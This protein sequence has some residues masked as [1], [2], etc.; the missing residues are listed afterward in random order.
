MILRS[1]GRYVS[2]RS[3]PRHSTARSPYGLVLNLR[4]IHSATFRRIPKQ[5]SFIQAQACF[6]HQVLG[7]WRPLLQRLFEGETEK[8][9]VQDL[10]GISSLHCQT[11]HYI[12]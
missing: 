8:V 4:K 12:W 7:G 5:G 6:Q 3:F 2:T 11:L 10:A 9:L 1:H